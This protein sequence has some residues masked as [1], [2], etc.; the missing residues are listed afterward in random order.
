MYSFLMTIHVSTCVLLILIVLLQ[1]G[2]GAGL[3]VFGGGG[4]DA[5]FTTPS[6]TGFMKQLTSGLAITFAVTSL[7]LTL[8]S[9]R[10]GMRSVTNTVDLPSAPAQEA[11]AAPAAPQASQ[12]KAPAKAGAVAGHAAP[13]K[14]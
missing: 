6:S 10:S 9:G 8:I 4:G 1:A 5:L 2:R 7:L 14:K 13:V 3:S 12:A 11:P